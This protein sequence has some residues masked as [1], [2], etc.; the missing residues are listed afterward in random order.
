[1]SLLVAITVLLAVQLGL[2]VVSKPAPIPYHDKSK[3]KL[4]AV[5][6]E[7]SVCSQIGID[8]IQKGGSAADGVSVVG[9][10]S[11]PTKPRLSPFLL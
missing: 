8:L 1:M 3:D 9:I 10:G 6:S 2:G 7:S 11:S 4:G 5:A